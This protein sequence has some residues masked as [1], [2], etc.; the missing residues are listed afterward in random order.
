MLGKD[1]GDARCISASSASSPG[2]LS[3]QQSS[4]SDGVFNGEVQSALFN[5]CRQGV[6]HPS[7]VNNLWYL[8]KCYVLAGGRGGGGWGCTNLKSTWKHCIK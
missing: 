6:C 8:T 4:D 3:S 5:A 1:V 7:Y 2:V